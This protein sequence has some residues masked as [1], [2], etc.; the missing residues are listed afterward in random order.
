MINPN[1]KPDEGDPQLVRD[2][3]EVNPASSQDPLHA[4]PTT[5]QQEQQEQQDEFSDPTEIDRNS[6]DDQR[7][8]DPTPAV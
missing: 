7:A 1:R 2:P 8:S 3:E 6:P 5:K 4:K